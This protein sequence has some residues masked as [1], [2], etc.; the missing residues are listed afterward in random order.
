VFNNTVGTLRHIFDLGIK[1][2]ARY[3]NPARAIKKARIV[4]KQLRLP[5]PSQFLKMLRKVENGGGA[6]AE[7]VLTWYA[8]LHLAVLEK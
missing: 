3:S 8:S 5:E 2:G 6:L 1:H 4:Q 7:T